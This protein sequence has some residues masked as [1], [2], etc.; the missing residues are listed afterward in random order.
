MVVGLE[1][2]YFPISHGLLLDVIC[3]L[4]AEIDTQLTE[5]PPFD[6]D[7]CDTAGRQPLGE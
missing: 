6:G 4:P 2:G 1:G 7:Y 5:C 3:L